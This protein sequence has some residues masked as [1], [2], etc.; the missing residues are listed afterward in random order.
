MRFVNGYVYVCTHIYIY[1]YIHIYIYTYIYIYV[2]TFFL[3][4]FGVCV[5]VRVCVC[6][7]CCLRGF[8]EF[9]YGKH[10]FLGFLDLGILGFRVLL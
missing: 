6:F 5:C 8:F 1:I 2:S 4:F 10:S 7:F 9:C 3:S